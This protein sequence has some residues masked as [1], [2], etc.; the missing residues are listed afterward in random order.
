MYTDKIEWIFNGTP[1]QFGGAVG[2]LNN[3]EGEWLIEVTHKSGG[4]IEVVFRNLEKEQEDWHGWAIAHARPMG[5]VISLHA[6][7]VDYKTRLASLWKRLVKELRRQGWSIDKLQQVRGE[8]KRKAAAAP[9]QPTGI[10]ISHIISAGDVNINLSRV[11]GHDQ[12]TTTTS[13]TITQHPSSAVQVEA[14][15]TAINLVELS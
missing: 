9:P 12:I 5:T 15:R 10:N 3:R 8:I 11:A 14:N 7:N 6:L 1:E 13:T 4:Q 2:V